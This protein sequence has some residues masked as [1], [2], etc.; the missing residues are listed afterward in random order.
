MH[1]Y[2]CIAFLT[3]GLE[4]ISLMSLEIVWVA[5]SHI[6]SCV[7]VCAHAWVFVLRPFVCLMEHTQKIHRICSF[8][9]WHLFVTETVTALVKT[10]D[11]GHTL[12]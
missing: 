1:L 2:Y 5:A 3:V 9:F 7:G 6:I 11:S 8:L 10:N 12:L 4:W